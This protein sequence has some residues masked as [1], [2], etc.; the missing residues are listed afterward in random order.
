MVIYCADHARSKHGHIRSVKRVATG[1]PARAQDARNDSGRIVYRGN[2]KGTSAPTA[3]GRW[4]R[5]RTEADATPPG[6]ESEAKVSTRVTDET[7]EVGRALAKFLGVGVDEWFYGPSGFS[8]K[9]QRAPITMAKA[10]KMLGIS[11]PTRPKKPLDWTGRAGEW[12]TLVAM[13]KATSG[14]K[15]VK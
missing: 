15:R 6:C 11:A 13:V 5:R 12:N 14:A 4:A 3:F 2:R 1:H 7:R 9:G 8:V 10:R